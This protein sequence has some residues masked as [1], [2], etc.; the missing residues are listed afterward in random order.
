MLVFFTVA[1]ILL[2]R[3]LASQFVLLHVI[4]VI[5]VVRLTC[6]FFGHTLGWQFDA[7]R[8]KFTTGRNANAVRAWQLWTNPLFHLRTRCATRSQAEDRCGSSSGHG[9]LL[10]AFG[11][12][13]NRRRRVDRRNRN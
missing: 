3:E 10:H 11:D 6:F 1:L 9:G 13:C 2:C 7:V 4:C 12:R 8:G 5:F